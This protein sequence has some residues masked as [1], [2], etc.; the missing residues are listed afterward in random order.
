MLTSWLRVER[1]QICVYF[2][3]VGG[4]NISLSSNCYPGKEIGRGIIDF[5][6]P[7]VLIG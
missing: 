2:R 5:R 7:N 1:G 3:E 6:G 4:L